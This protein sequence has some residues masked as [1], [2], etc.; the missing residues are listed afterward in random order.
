MKYINDYI[1]YVKKYPQQFGKKIKDMIRL[2]EKLLK[3]PEIIYKERDV[4]LYFKFCEN[5]R[6]TTGPLKGQVFIP[7]IEQKFIAACLLGLKRYNDV[8]GKWLRF[9]KQLDLFVARK[10]G[11]TL[12]I[13]SLALFIFADPSEGSPYAVCV[14]ENKKQARLMYENIVENINWQIYDDKGKLVTN[15]LQQLFVEKNDGAEKYIECTINGGKLEYITGRPK[16]KDGSSPSLI[17]VDESHEITQDG[18]YY[19]LTTGIGARPQPVI[20]NISTAGIVPDSLHE[21]LYESDDIELSKKALDKNVRRLMLIYEIDAEDDIED[22]E[23]W[24]KANPGMVE[25]RPSMEFLRD[26]WANMKNAPDT[27]MKFVAKHLNRP[28]NA[29]ISFFDPI[30]LTNCRSTIT[31]DMV[32]DN[33]AFCGTDLSKTT[34]LTNATALIP[35]NGKLAV[36]QAYF[37]AEERLNKNSIKD[38]KEYVLFKDISKANFELTRNLVIITPGSYIRKEFVTQWYVELVKKYKVNILKS[39]YDSWDSK[40]WITDM[41]ANGFNHE[42][43]EYNRENKTEKR[44]FGIM[45]EVRQ[46]PITLTQPIELLKAFMDD[47]LIIYDKTNKILEYNFFNLK[48]K[49]N[50]NGGLQPEKV[51]STGRIDG[52]IGIFNALVAYLRAKELY[53]HTLDNET[54]KKIFPV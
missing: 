3:S 8:H 42:I 18:V 31:K 50:V 20:I 13:S 52:A 43:I 37:M 19:A 7:S 30:S 40:E 41:E 38:G 27:K 11:K 1:E 10:W 39:G 45:T 46:G 49:I 53:V 2:L 29:A 47:K 15:P 32:Y 25:N 23:C 36:I 48:I 14:A 28:I 4:E 54:F 44:D 16:G 26:Q 34:D 24:I 5:F 22:E 9:F 35:V 33:Y 17:I 6:H 51:K 21:K 12:F